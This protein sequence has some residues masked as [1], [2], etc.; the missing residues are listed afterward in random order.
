MAA[1]PAADRTAK[2]DVDVARVGPMT[3]HVALAGKS[4]SQIDAD[5]KA[6]AQAVCK[7]NEGVEFTSCIG[8]AVRDANAQLRTIAWIERPRKLAS[9]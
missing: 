4:R 9:N 8:D 6:A 3:I 5:V 1:N 2:A 7:A